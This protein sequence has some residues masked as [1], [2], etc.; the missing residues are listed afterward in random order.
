MVRC[1][2]SDVR[3]GAATAMGKLGTAMIALAV[4]GVVVAPPA[5]AATSPAQQ[6]TAPLDAKCDGN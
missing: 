2:L 1:T 4:I 3:K 5:A 6:P